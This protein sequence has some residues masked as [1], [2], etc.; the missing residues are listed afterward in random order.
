MTGWR[1]DLLG[2]RRGSVFSPI[3]RICLQMDNREKASQLHIGRG[4]IGIGAQ[5]WGLKKKLLEIDELMTPAK[6]RIVHE[7]HPE[8]SF[9]EMNGGQPLT[10]SKRTPEGERQ[11]IK[12]LKDNDFPESF[13]APLS[14]LHSGRNDFIDACAALWT[15]ERISRGIAR[16]LPSDGKPEHDARGLDMAIWF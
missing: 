12:A 3:G 9:C 13:L 4:G 16:R 1:D 7:V 11:R 2:S 6:Q 8:V 10:Q 5:C 14:T 15:A